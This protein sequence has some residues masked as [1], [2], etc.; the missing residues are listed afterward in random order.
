M[1]SSPLW[2]VTTSYPSAS[3]IVLR[4]SRIAGSSSITKILTGVQRASAARLLPGSMAV[5]GKMLNGLLAALGGDDLISVSL[6]Y[7]AQKLADRR[8]VIDNQDTDRRAEGFG[9]TV[10]AGLNG[11]AGQNAHIASWWRMML[12]PEHIEGNPVSAQN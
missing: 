12:R 3:N 1:A 10:A 6:Q 9:S 7:R 11:G 8:I 5:L 4:S 2:A